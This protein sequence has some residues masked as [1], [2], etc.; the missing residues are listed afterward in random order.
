M[1]DN[2]LFDETDL[3]LCRVATPFNNNNKNH[4][5]NKKILLIYANSF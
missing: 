3:A 2:K 1:L 4:K 5:Q